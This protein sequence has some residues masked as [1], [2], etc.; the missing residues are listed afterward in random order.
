MHLSCGR[1]CIIITVPFLLV[2]KCVLCDVSKKKKGG[3][4]QWIGGG[5]LFFFWGQVTKLPLST[6]VFEFDLAALNPAQDIFFWEG[7]FFHNLGVGTCNEKPGKLPWWSLVEPSLKLTKI[8]P[9]HFGDF[10]PAS[11]LGVLFG[12]G[13]FQGG[14]LLG[15]RA[16]EDTN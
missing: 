14:K 13:P 15:I 16:R 10:S 8:P 5:P 7:F 2:K 4:Y 3:S 1:K 12:Q 9:L 11:F 6:T